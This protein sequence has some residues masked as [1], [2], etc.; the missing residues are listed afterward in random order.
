MDATGRSEIFGKLILK[1]DDERHLLR[2]MHLVHTTQIELAEAEWSNAERHHTIP[3]ATQREAASLI[4]ALW[5]DRADLE[6]TN[7]MYWYR[8]YAIRYE[9]GTEVP[10]DDREQI[11]ILHQIMAADPSIKELNNA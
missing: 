7:Y 4:A 6:K 1:R 5:H 11:E 2:W 9:S 10:E 3:A 8:E